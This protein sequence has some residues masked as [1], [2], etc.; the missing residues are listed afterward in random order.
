M[1]LIRIAV[2]SVDPTVGAVR[3]NIDRML[4][5]AREMGRRA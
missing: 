5:M 4:A 2:A 1:R 3:S